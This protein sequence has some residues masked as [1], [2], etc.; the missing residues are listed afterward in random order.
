M[1]SSNVYDVTA[2]PA[3]NPHD[4]IGA[5]INDIIADIKH[6]Q[7][8]A[9]V[10]DGGKPGAL[11]YIPPGDY[12]LKTQVAIDISFLRIAGSG[13][14]FTSSSIRFNTPP[15]ELRQ[16]HEVWPGGSRVLVE[17]A[18]PAGATAE[19]GAAFL[20]KRSGNPRISSVEFADFC[21][22]GLHF[23]GAPDDDAENT[24]RNGKTGIHVASANDSLR[25]TGMGLVYLEHGIVSHHAD[26]SA[27]E[28]NFIAECGNCI[29]LRGMGQASR[30]ANNLIGAGYDG[31]SIYAENFGGLL[32]SGNNVFP[33]G[34]SS[35]ALSGVVRSSI[36]GNRLHSFYPGMLVFSG[37]CSENLVASNHFFRDRE[38]WAPM[39]RYDNGLDDQFGL[40]HLNGDN[41]S[42]MANHI[43]ESIDTRYLKPADEKPVIIRIV[44]GRGNYVAN[45]HIVATTESSQASD[46]PSSDCFATQVEAILAT[47]NLTALEVIAV[48]VEAGASHNTVL[49]SGSDAE[50]LMDRSVNAFRGTPVP[51]QMAS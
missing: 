23:S 51:G 32:V 34:K 38:P 18:A 16:W 5:V 2:W 48:K 28:G 22:D 13:H 15:Q 12:R 50:V 21:I 19:A 26:A 36:S 33:R 43:S 9:D 10:N 7:R 46:A 17:L 8:V 6:R 39:T 29:E 27:I 4:D 31:H 47:R 44:S 25:I 41:N 24:Y 30:I 11:I 1:P 45:N 3:G 14:G 35:I 37:N 42:V 49:D 40:L 20:V